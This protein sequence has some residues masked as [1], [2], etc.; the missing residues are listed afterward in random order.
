MNVYISHLGEAPLRGVREPIAC[1]PG[2]LREVLEQV[3]ERHPGFLDLVVAPDGSG[4]Q[5]SVL[6]YK[7]IETDA[8]GRWLEGT[9]TQPVS[10]LD[11]ALAPSDNLLVARFDP[12]RLMTVLTETLA[13]TDER[14]EHADGSHGYRAFMSGPDEAAGNQP[15]WVRGEPEALYPFTSGRPILELVTAGS[16][17]LNQDKL[18]PARLR[19]AIADLWELGDDF[20]LR[21]FQEEALLHILRELRASEASARRPLLLSIPTGGGKTEAFLIPLIAHLYDRKRAALHDHAPLPAQVRTLILYPTRALANDQAKRI[22]EIL[23]ALN[24]G[25]VEA[26]KVNVGVLTGDTPNSGYNLGTEK[27]LL[28]VCPACSAVLTDFPNRENANGAEVYY[29]RCSCGAEIDFFR[30]TRW[31]ILNAPPDMLIT[32]PD[33]IN[34]AL[35]SPRYYRALFGE[36]IEAVVFDEIHMYE[37]VFGCNVA[38]L[39]RRFEEACGHRPLYVGAS[40]TIRNAKGLASLIFDADLEA[41]RYLRPARQGTPITD[42]ERPYVDYD[43][44]PDRYRHHYAVAPAR[45]KDRFQKTVT[46][47]LN[48]ADAIGHLVRDPHFRKTLIFANFRQDTDDIV[49]FLRD[50]EARYYE[51]YVAHVLPKLASAL[52]ST[53]AIVSAD[54]TRAEADIARAIDRW[55]RGGQVIGA[56]YEPPLEIGWHRG[57]LEKEE[58]IKAV[59]RFAAAR[60]LTASGEAGDEYPID[61]MAATKTLELGIDIGDVTTVMNNT[62]PFSV[63]EYVQRVGRG[64]RRRDSLALTIVNPS[65][66]LDFYFLRHFDRYAH[67]TAADFED[68]PIIISNQEVLRS[69]LYARLLDHLAWYWDDQ[70]KPDLQVVDLK[71]YRITVDD[72]PIGLAGDGD[73]FANAVFDAVLP[74]ASIARL[75]AWIQREADVIPGVEPAEI[76]ADRLR[77]WWVAKIRRLRERIAKGDLTD[78]DYLSGWHA[79]DRD[80]VPDMRSAGPQVGVY[81]VREKGDDELRDTLARSR[82]IASRPPRGFATQ[83]SVT[84][85]VEGIKARNVEAETGLKQVFAQH[86]DA[87]DYF[88]RMFSGDAQG[89]PFPG[90]PMEVLIQVDFQTPQDLSVK[91]HPYRFY[92]SRCGATYSDKRPGDERCKVCGNELR[93]LTEIYVCGGCGAVY[94]PPVPKVCVNPGCVAQAKHRRDGTSFIEAVKKVG[95]Y[96]RHNDYFRFTALPRLKWQCRGCGAEINYHAHYELPQSILGQ[97]DAAVWS[98]DTPAGIARNFLYRPEAYYGKSYDAR[99]WHRA[100][101]SCKP[102]RD[103]NSYHKIHVTNIPTHRSVIH[104]Y[105]IQNEPYAPSLD[106]KLGQWTFD[107]VSVISLAREMYRRFFSYPNQETRIFPSVI[108]PE[109]NS[110]LAN[111]YDTHAALLRLSD[112]MTAF[113][114]THPLAQDYLKGYEDVCASQPLGGSVDDE[115]D[116][117]L[118]SG[119][120]SSPHPALL[121]WERD[122]K[123]DPRRMWCDVVRGVVPNRICQD[124]ACEHCRIEAFDRRRFARYLVIHTIKHAL[125]NAMP[126]FT[127]ANKNQIRGYIYPN[128]RR[129]YDLAL[130]DRIVGGSGCLYLLRAN[131]DTIW[132]MTGELLNAARHDQ[133]Q[134]LLPYT[135]SRYNRDLCTPL[136][137]A[138]Y[139]FLEGQGA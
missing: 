43:A 61:V 130:V 5:S 75:R 104:E 91:Y 49:R 121:A 51:P 14:L 70:G 92:C 135:C 114:D 29:A 4:L 137:F 66:P 9:D 55:Y 72:Q 113:L 99:G 31:D 108:F 30:L 84:F 64:G 32:S 116:R 1:S 50:Q 35:Q 45:F 25:V 47:T 86:A 88:H 133:G 65:N 2:T 48:I 52:A 127:G 77:E 102:C 33:M 22:T 18:I 56:L 132:E 20:R 73:V 110:Y 6:I 112:A 62:A 118:E 100:R 98:Y 37:G 17:S 44:P 97:L 23:Y 96:D 40:A 60:K 139:E 109:S 8:Q 11:E 85:R 81:L 94:M 120:M 69:H 95:D 3:D 27:S 83:G 13:A 90:N 34:R 10:D 53:G 54:L 122:R 21:L 128:D 93:Q 89:S 123:P 39:L 28:Q 87:V 106:N 57:G 63:N 15:L 41:V 124:D 117:D 36:A 16:L 67:P 71:N 7:R 19:D 68:A 78:N 46:A 26:N 59:N 101:F 38:H 136:A 126:R 105:I 58:R 129:E 12:D 42:E 138:F 107:R 74:L 82:A 125:I 103:A 111:L 79:Q 76:S 24:L 131:W 80:L 134:L 119:E 115:D